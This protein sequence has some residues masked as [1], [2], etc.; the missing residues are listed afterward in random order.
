MFKEKLVWKHVAGFIRSGAYIKKHPKLGTD[1]LFY[2][3]MTA[4]NRPLMFV[5]KRTFN[6][7]IKHRRIKLD[8]KTGYYVMN[9]VWR[10]VRKDK[11]VKVTKRAPKKKEAQLSLDIKTK[12]V[13]NTKLTCS[14]ITQNT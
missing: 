11:K 4:D 12:K 14:N 6:L 10:K 13:K 3:L 9:P 7:L 2:K 1:K 8:T 5:T